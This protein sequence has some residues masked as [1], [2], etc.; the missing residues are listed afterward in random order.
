MSAATPCADGHHVFFDGF[1]WWDKCMHCGFCP[2]EPTQ[3]GL[4]L[5][6]AELLLAQSKTQEELAGTVRVLRAEVEMLK[7]RV[8]ALERGT[9]D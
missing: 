1:K 2:S 3:S 5:V 8:G 7:A 9:D 4:V 6:D